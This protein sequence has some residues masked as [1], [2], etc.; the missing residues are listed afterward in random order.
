MVRWEDMAF[1]KDFGGLGFSETRRMNIA[2]LAKWIIKI[3]SDE[4][5]LCLEVLRRKYLQGGVF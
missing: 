4:K 2:L 3:E 5:S 1:P